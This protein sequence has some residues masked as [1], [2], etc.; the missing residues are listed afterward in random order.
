MLGQV[1][2]SSNEILQFK[3]RPFRLC[4]QFTRLAN[5]LLFCFCRTL[6]LSA[7]CTNISV[8]NPRHFMVFGYIA[9]YNSKAKEMSDATSIYSF[10]L[11]IGWIAKA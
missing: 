10:K 11:L 2:V 4:C 3:R 1:P 5:A 6:L 8:Y 9:T 7:L